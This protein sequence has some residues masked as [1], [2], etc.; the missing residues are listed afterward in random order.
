MAQGTVF[1]GVAL[2][3]CRLKLL[4]RFLQKL[5]LSQTYPPRTLMSCSWNFLDSSEEL[6]YPVKFHL[7]FDHCSSPVK[8]SMN[9]GSAIHCDHYLSLFFVTCKHG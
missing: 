2:A 5:L 6:V 3:H 1:T 4:N 8:T 9:P 7:K